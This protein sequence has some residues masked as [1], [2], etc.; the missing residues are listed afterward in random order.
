VRTAHKHCSHNGETKPVVALRLLRGVVIE[1]DPGLDQ[2][3]MALEIT[4]SLAVTLAV[5]YR[6]AR[7]AHP[8]WTSAV[9]TVQLS[10][11]LAA[12]LHAQHREITVVT[13]AIG[14]VETF[15]SQ[16]AALDARPS[17][18]A[19]TYA[20][21]PLAL[22]AGA[23][24]GIALTPHHT[25]GLVVLAF[26]SGAGAYAR[27]LVALLGTRAAAW[28]TSLVAGFL[29]GFLGGQALPLHEFYRYVAI[30]SPGGCGQPRTAIGCVQ[31]SRRYQAGER[32]LSG[33]AR[34]L[35][36]ADS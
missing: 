25:L 3:R 26:V 23:S 29:A 4:L 6:F 35:A 11:T 8:Y 12:K 24:L 17:E 30:V 13:L 16:L 1:L 15:I 21:F 33:G 28:G 2:L 18:Q 31:P 10:P 20:G 36:R 19:I 34:R 7:I 5:S 22:S 27:R 32:L 14:G 9:R